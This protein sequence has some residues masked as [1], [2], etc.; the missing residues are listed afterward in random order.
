MVRLFVPPSTMDRSDSRI[1]GTIV[2]SD[3]SG[4]D[5]EI[6]QDR[7]PPQALTGSFGNADSFKQGALLCETG[8]QPSVFGSYTRGADGRGFEPL[9]PCGTHAFQACTIDRCVTHPFNSSS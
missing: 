2:G 4:I 6:E 3:F 8:M 5:A 7:W 9:V 1:P